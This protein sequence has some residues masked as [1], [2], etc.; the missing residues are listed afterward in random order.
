MG[1]SSFWYRPTR[2]VPDQR[3]LNGRVCVCVCVVIDVCTRVQLYCKLYLD[4]LEMSELTKNVGENISFGKTA[5]YL[6][7]VWD[8]VSV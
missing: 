8:C 7:L 5:H 2:V 3:P 6:V 4:N 1:E